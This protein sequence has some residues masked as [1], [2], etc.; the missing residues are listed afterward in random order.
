MTEWIS[1]KDRLPKAGQTIIGWNEAV[2]INNESEPAQI[3]TYF[4]DKPAN[5]KYPVSTGKWIH[6]SPDRG[7]VKAWSWRYSI[8]HWMPL[9][10]P[11]EVEDE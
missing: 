2:S 4:P 11:P 8:T 6:W 9:P 1:V 3:Y 7:Q 5:W 10:E